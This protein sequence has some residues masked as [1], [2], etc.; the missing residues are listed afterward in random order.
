MNT[1][2]FTENG[3]GEPTVLKDGFDSRADQVD[4][5]SNRTRP[6]HAIWKAY[7]YLATFGE[8]S[9]H[10]LRRRDEPTRRHNSRMAIRRGADSRVDAHLPE[11]RARLRYTSTDGAPSWAPTRFNV[12][13][14]IC[15]SAELRSS[16]RGYLGS[17]LRFLPIKLG[18]ECN[19]FAS[20]AAL[21]FVLSVLV[22]ID[23][24]VT[25]ADRTIIFIE[26][27]PI[28]AEPPEY[29]VIWQS[30][31]FV[32]PCRRWWL[33]TAGSCLVSGTVRLAAIYL[34]SHICYLD[35]IIFNLIGCSLSNC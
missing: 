17:P 9:G 20:G 3:P 32:P 31:F 34:L 22:E 23:L 30:S 16:N 29:R 2:T 21:T 35:V 1:E 6:H 13:P 24:V 5:D 18:M 4:L 8:A 28:G 7:G 10:D 19:R 14:C 12:H 26:N 33:W 25:I 11:L 15:K 27:I